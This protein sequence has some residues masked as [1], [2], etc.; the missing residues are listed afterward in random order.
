MN[1]AV[2]RTSPPPGFM[3]SGALGTRVKRAGIKEPCQPACIH[4]GVHSAYLISLQSCTLFAV[5]EVIY[6]RD[7]VLFRESHWAGLYS[8]LSQWWSNPK[9]ISECPW[10]FF[11][12][13]PIQ[14]WSFYSY[15]QQRAHG[16]KRYLFSNAHS[17][18]LN[19]MEVYF[20][21]KKIY[22]YL[23]TT[24]K[25]FRGSKKKSGASLSWEGIYVFF[26]PNT[27]LKVV[28]EDKR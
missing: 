16:R 24:Y 22:R 28:R 4:I 14:I 8:S 23:Q 21:W 2:C 9:V 12:S 15:R 10:A 13:I 1:S 27:L 25:Y 26:P 11:P 3:L 19:P 20:R 6:E 17:F 7:A 18:P 5:P